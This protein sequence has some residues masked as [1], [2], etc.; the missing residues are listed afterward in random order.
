MVARSIT[1]KKK[2]KGC[3]NCGELGHKHANCPYPCHRCGGNHSFVRC[4]AGDDK[5]LKDFFESMKLPGAKCMVVDD[6]RRKLASFNLMNLSA[7]DMFRA[8]TTKTFGEM[9][10]EEFLTYA[11]ERKDFMRHLFEEFDRSGSGSINRHEFKAALE[12]LRMDPNEDE[13]RAMIALIDRPTAG[14]K[15]PPNGK[16]EWPEFRDF[17]LLVV[18]TGRFLDFS[19]MADQ[20]LHVAQ[21]ELGV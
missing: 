5:E 7:H 16:I 18:P 3:Y 10:E 17:F 12:H 6:V 21:E 9:T 2:F 14:G 20:W 11:N 1:Q 19:P 15:C 8:A 13:V 4:T